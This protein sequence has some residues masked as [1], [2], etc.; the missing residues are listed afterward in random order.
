MEKFNK[1]IL[2]IEGIDSKAIGEYSNAI[3]YDCISGIKGYYYSNVDFSGENPVIT[4]TKE[5]GVEPTEPFAIS[6][7]IGDIISMTNGSKFYNCV[8]ILPSIS[9]EVP[10]GVAFT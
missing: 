7:E 3:G 8:T 9:E 2:Y 4:L 6:Y 5:Q 1:K 10:I